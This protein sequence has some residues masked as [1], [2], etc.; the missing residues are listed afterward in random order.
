MYK[1]CQVHD[2]L[3]L[4]F[5]LAICQFDPLTCLASPRRKLKARPIH[6]P[7]AFYRYF[8]AS[9]RYFVFTHL[10]GNL[11]QHFAVFDYK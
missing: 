2:M 9:D 5:L 6:S 3:Y 10:D 11:T 8:S 4:P 1:L 7:N